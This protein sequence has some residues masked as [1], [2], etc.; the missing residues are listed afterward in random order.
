MTGTAKLNWRV[1]APAWEAFTEWVAE[2]RPQTE[3]YL[4]YEIE[5]AMREYVDA[6]GHAAAIETLLDEHTAGV[7]SS[8]VVPDDNWRGVATTKLGYRVDAALKDQFAGFANEHDARSYGVA[9]GRALS[10]YVDG[11]R[12]RRVREKLEA[13]LTGPTVDPAT[14]GVETTTATSGECGATAQSDSSTAT[15]RGTTGGSTLVEAATVERIA[16]GFSDAQQLTRGALD[17]V[18]AREVGGDHETIT[19]YRA[20]VLEALEMVE[21]PHE[22]HQYMT[23]AYRESTTVWADLD[24]AERLV[25][26]R[27]WLATAALE[28]GTQH[29]EWS[30]TDVIERFE[31][32]AGAGPS[33]QYA[34]DLM[35]AAA[36]VAGFEYGRFQVSARQ[37][38]KVRL[39]VDLTAVDRSILEWVCAETA[40]DAHT[41][42]RVAGRGPPTAAAGAADGLA[43]GDD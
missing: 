40:I 20:A 18:I 17:R 27:R 3:G 33:H 39:R 5:R 42:H 19:A 16:D 36:D 13:A 22:D 11:G 6:D 24:K 34:Y 4:R 38:K 26:L 9:L 41:I 14:E 23:E 15:A 7:S 29:Y 8:T 43:P 25:L 10:E 31:A 21:H 35:E 2:N 37:Q 1:P 30:Y 28:A 32:D 12:M